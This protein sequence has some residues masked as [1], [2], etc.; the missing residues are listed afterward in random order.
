MRGEDDGSLN[1]SRLL[2][3]VEASPPVAAVEVLARELARMVDATAVS[4]LVP[5]FS[6]TALVRMVRTSSAG[7]AEADAGEQ[8]AELPLHGSVHQEVLATQELRLERVD[9]GWLALVPVT[10][11]GDVIGL[12]ELSLPQV[13]DD[14][15]VDYLSAAAHALAYVLVAT[16]RHTDLFEWAR[17][18]VP[19]SLAAEIQHRLLPSSYTIEGGPFTLAGWLEPAATIGG[20]TFDYTIDRE[21]LYAS[22]TD[23]VGHSNDAALLATLTVGS[24]RNTRRS[25]ASPAEQ[26]DRANEALH[27]GARA[28]QFVTGHVLRVRLGDGAAEIIGKRRFG[29][30]GPVDCRG[31]P[32][33][34]LL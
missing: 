21:Y 23:A 13:P 27:E 32:P 30:A 9:Y 24:L 2:A 10:E 1:L 34:D 3:A 18:D 14:D 16:R 15:V 6:G 20:D 4:L 33:I 22:L 5:N 11:R 8:A 17:R 25:S 29:I 19:F 28:D 31:L 12:L 26:A 7:S